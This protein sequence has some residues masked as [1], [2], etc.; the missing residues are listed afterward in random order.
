MPNIEYVKI[1]VVALKRL[2]I[3]VLNDSKLI[4]DSIS[5]VSESVRYLYDWVNDRVDPWYCTQATNIFRISSNTYCT[6]TDWSEFELKR[7]IEESNFLLFPL[8]FFHKL[9]RHFPENIRYAGYAND[10]KLITQSYSAAFAL[11]LK[12][13]SEQHQLE[14]CSLGCKLTYINDAIMYISAESFEKNIHEICSSLNGNNGEH[15]NTDDVKSTKQ[16]STKNNTNN[17][18]EQKT[19]TPTTQVKQWRKKEAY[20][21]WETD[22]K[23]TRLNSSHSAKSR[24]PSSA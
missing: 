19:T 11:K 21:D 9:K 1:K 3:L 17:Q 14:L 12:H 6:D 5:C 13:I 4:F 22:R 18:V 8:E 20:R 24:M 15:T 23:S 2:P 16:V 7:T 10:A